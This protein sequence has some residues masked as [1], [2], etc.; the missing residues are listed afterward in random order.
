MYTF[1]VRGGAGGQQ[2]ALCGLQCNSAFQQF[3]ISKTRFK[4]SH[5]LLDS[6]LDLSNHTAMFGPRIR[7][8]CCRSCSSGSCHVL[9]RSLC[10]DVREFRRQRRG[11]E[12]CCIRQR[13]GTRTLRLIFSGLSSTDRN[14][15]LC[16]CHISC[17]PSADH[18]SA[19]SDF[20]FGSGCSPG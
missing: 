7:R 11:D 1:Q 16:V 15:S 2:P 12:R 19:S 20:E 6:V 3:F 4:A 18:C 10:S 8:H 5:R 9:I 13:Q 17:L 14:W